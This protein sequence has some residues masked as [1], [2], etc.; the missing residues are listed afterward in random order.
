MGN[1]IL[2]I[3][4]NTRQRTQ[5]R[6]S[7]EAWG[8]E[9]FIAADGDEAAKLSVDKNIPFIISEFKPNG[10]NGLSL[11]EHIRQKNETAQVLFTSEAPAIEDAV[12]AIKAG[13]LDFF[14]KPVDL[15]QL[16][17]I[18]EKVF[19]GNGQS[20]APPPRRTGAETPECHIITGN[21]EM[22]KLLKMAGQVAD[23]C[24]SVLVQGESGTGKE[25]F[26]RLIHNKSGRAERPFVA[27][28]C[29]ALPETLLESELFGHEK[30]AFTGAIARKPGK[31]ELAHQGTL[32]LDEITEMDVRLQS[33]LLRAIQ[34][35]QI[36]RVGGVQPVSVDVRI[37][38]TTNRDI[39]TAVRQGDFREDLFYRIATIPLSI[40][41][42]RQR[43]EDIKL[44]SEYFIDKYNRLDNRN[45]KKLSDAALI[46]LERYPFNGNVRE[47]ENII[48]RAILLS[49]GKTI[50]EGNLML[51][52]AV[53]GRT[54][55]GRQE[56]VLLSAEGDGGTLKDVEKKTIFQTL[57]KT[58]GNRTR[59]AQTLGISVRTL[60]NKLNEY[61][62]NED[63][64]E[65][66]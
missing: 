11:L 29:S 25:L 49:D 3:E 31:F 48:H 33:K 65:S 7:I 44:L 54:G 40:P 13:A 16:R 53:G 14:T 52:T 66:E 64:S 30:G 38:A 63:S 27:V 62:E 46:C 55:H 23:S 6:N 1:R 15:T 60:R 21:R 43:R 17:Y 50:T 22:E 47:L 58:N 59:A 12:S 24:A 41:P 56:D 35:N 42:L 39:D 10:I 37:I 32:L 9:V 34:E 19:N 51:A 8:Y 2:L 5:L 26:A 45:V 57:D 18:T 20:A 28:N 61:K 4:N 36:D